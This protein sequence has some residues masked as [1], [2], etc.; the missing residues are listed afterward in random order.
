[1]TELVEKYVNNCVGCPPEMGCMG[2]ACPYHPHK[3]QCLVYYCD[4]CGE[5]VESEHDLY[6]VPGQN[7]ETWV[8]EK[9]CAAAEQEA[10]NDG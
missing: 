2:Q 9:C 3:S 10:E 4:A 6:R 5:A 1:M 7:E 8:C